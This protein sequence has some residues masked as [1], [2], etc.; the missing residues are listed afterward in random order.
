MLISDIF[1]HFLKFEDGGNIVLAVLV[2]KSFLFF[3]SSNV[4]EA[5]NRILHLFYEQHVLSPLKNHYQ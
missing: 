1:I 5:N 4:A 2:E 3:V